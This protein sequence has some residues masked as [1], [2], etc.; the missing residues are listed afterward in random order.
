MAVTYTYA[1]NGLRVSTQG[2]LSDVVREIDVN[3]WGY[4]GDFAFHMPVTVRLPAANPDSFT[5]FDS[6][7]EAQAVA[8]ID[9][10]TSTAHAKNHIANVL[11]RMIE[12][13]AMQAKPL[14]WGR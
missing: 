13:A 6:L 12:D 5:A 10:S 4:D 8:W 3:V 11:S 1:I 9:A 14:P 2:G 7:S